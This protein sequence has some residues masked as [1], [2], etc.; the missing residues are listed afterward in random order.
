MISS[1][2][3]QLVRPE[4]AGEFFEHALQS[5]IHRQGFR[6][7]HETTL[8]LRKLLTDF[9]HSD[10]LFEHSVDGLQLRP[11]AGMYAEAVNAETVERRDSML[12]RLGDVAL[13]IAGL[14]PQSLSRSLVDID[15]YINMGGSAYGYLAESRQIA[16]GTSA[17]KM[18]F[19]D[20]SEH[21]AGFVDVLA[22]VGDSTSLANDRDVLRLYEMWLCS[23]SNNAAGKLQ[24][25][26]IVPVRIDRQT[27]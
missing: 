9:I 22:E 23:G 1:K 7:C 18:I 17:F 20:L 6:P 13:F 14:F 26:G 11:L 8:Y 3:E 10:R 4:D 19:R 25:L 15:Y 21:F 5:A 16:T 2:E 24:Q 12:R 27:H